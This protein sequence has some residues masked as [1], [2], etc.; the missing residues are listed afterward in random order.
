M[1]VPPAGIFQPSGLFRVEGADRAT[2]LNGYTTQEVSTLPS[3]E[4]R[5]GAIT[6]WKGQMTDLVTFVGLENTVWVVGTATRSAAV[7][8][9]LRRFLVGVDVRIEPV[10]DWVSAVLGTLPVSQGV[11]TG[12]ACA[13]ALGLDRV[14]GDEAL[15]VASLP[16]PAWPASRLCVPAP[17]AEAWAEA[18]DAAGHTVP[19]GEMRERARLAWGW[20]DLD[21]DLPPACNP[22]EA[23]M[24]PFVRMDKGCYLGQEVVARLVNYKRIQRLLMGVGFSAPV[25]AGTS[26]F[27]EGREIGRMGSSVSTT[28]GAWIGLALVTAAEAVAGREVLTAE[29]L[30]GMLEDR[31]LW[32]GA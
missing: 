27:V 18:L 24:G 8:K 1:S 14:P 5:L 12:E 3:G 16:A 30:V 17:T 26:L 15:L 2:F 29:G 6:D 4:A 23:R 13:R 22:W 31:P 28:E 21:L 25:P 10:Q 11:V 20:P 9:G 7:V 32:H 19:D